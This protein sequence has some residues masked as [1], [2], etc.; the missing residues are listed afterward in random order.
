[1]NAVGPSNKGR[2]ALGPFA[3][4]SEF[5]TQWQKKAQRC[6]SHLGLFSVSVELWHVSQCLFARRGRALEK[7]LF[8]GSARYRDGDNPVPEAIMTG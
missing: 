1:M 8:G 7:S 2:C 3:T 5:Q 4:E 6:A